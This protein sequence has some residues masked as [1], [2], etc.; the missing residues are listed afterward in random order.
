VEVEAEVRYEERSGRGEPVR[1]EKGGAIKMIDL[2]VGSITS[3]LVPVHH[4]LIEK[5][6]ELEGEREREK[7]RRRRKMEE[8]REKRSECQALCIDPC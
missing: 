6:R 3:H 8:V 4:E 2:G 7:E 1:V 5:R